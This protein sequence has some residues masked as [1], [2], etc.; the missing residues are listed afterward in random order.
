MYKIQKE[1]MNQFNF[2]PKRGTEVC[3]SLIYV[4][5]Y[6]TRLTQWQSPINACSFI[7]KLVINLTVMS[8]LIHSPK[9]KYLCFKLKG[10]LFSRNTFYALRMT[11]LSAQLS[12]IVSPVTQ[13][14][15][16][17]I[18]TIWIHTK[19]FIPAVT[20]RSVRHSQQ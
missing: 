15:C 2:T 18:Y 7:F 16:T 4:V 14:S 1:P 3:Q 10:Y 5:I 19:Y 13:K 8:N 11:S 12:D 20:Y 17:N 9:F 6:I